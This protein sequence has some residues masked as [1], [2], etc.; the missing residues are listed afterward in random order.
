[1]R[2]AGAGFSWFPSD[3]ASARIRSLFSQTADVPGAF[4][5]PVART[6]HVRNAPCFATVSPTAKGEATALPSPHN[7]YNKTYFFL[8]LKPSNFLFFTGCPFSV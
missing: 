4:E 1:M 5:N 8:K 6:G 3:N 7:P 2:C